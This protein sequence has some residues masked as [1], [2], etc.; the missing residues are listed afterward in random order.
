MQRFKTSR[1]FRIVSLA[2]VLVLVLSAG[3]AYVVFGSNH[4]EIV[5]A[6]LTPGGQLKDVTIDGPPNC[7]GQNTLISW[8]QTG[9]VGPTGPAGDVGPEGPQGEPGPEGP[10]GPQGPQGPDGPEGPKGD[11]GD[12]GTFSGTFESDN[13]AFS[14]SVTDAGIVLSGPDNEILLGN[15]S[16]SMSNSI[17]E[18]TF[19]STGDI[20]LKAVEV[21]VEGLH[22]IEL[23][24]GGSL[25]IEAGAIATLNG[26]LVQLGC[27]AG[28][29]PIARTNDGVVVSTQSGLGTIVGGSSSVFAC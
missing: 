19:D 1:A 12:T 2:F 5:Y 14:I 6:C 13:G 25:T 4:D 20:T 26:A 9:P 29:S 23:S 21:D 11:R 22:S 10:E 3:S 24:S 27:S 16:M 17:A 7:P 8:N 28:G 15:N 18:I